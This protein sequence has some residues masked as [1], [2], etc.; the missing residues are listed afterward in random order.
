MIIEQKWIREKT[1]I[2][3]LKTIKQV[4]KENHDKDEDVIVRPGQYSKLTLA[5]YSEVFNC[6]FFNPS[7]NYWDS[8]LKQTPNA[9]SH[10]LPL[11]IHLPVTE[12]HETNSKRVECFLRR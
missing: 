11:T 7:D 10:V 2:T 8:T 1:A 3:Y 5:E 4:T 6:F 9:S 12:R